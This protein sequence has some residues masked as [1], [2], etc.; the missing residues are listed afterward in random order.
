MERARYQESEQFDRQALAI[1]EKFYGPDHPQTASAL[2]QLGRSLYYERHYDEA[3]TLLRRA[4][5]IQERVHGPV[6]PAVASAL[7]ELGNIASATG[8][9]RE[10]EADFRRMVDIYRTVYHDHHY[11]IGIAQSNLATVYFGEK[12]Y[13][14]AEALYRE[15]I[16][17]LSDTLPANHTSIGIARIKLGRVLLQERR[18]ADAEQ[19]S[20][21]GYRILQKQ[22]S[23]SATWILNARKDLREIYEALGQPERAREFAERAGE[24]QPVAQAPPKY[25]PP[26]PTKHPWKFKP[27]LRSRAFGRPECSTCEWPAARL[28]ASLAEAS[29]GRVQ[30]LDLA[31]ASR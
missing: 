18:Y 11:L 16:R 8:E 6:H 13:A 24:V 7:N 15:A 1:D 14:R 27:R 23:P 26:K 9:Y 3:E 17:R 5:A 20:L 29:D 28:L 30:A 4:L 19:E 25:R 21:A 22:M 10:A 12:E 31:L 2:T